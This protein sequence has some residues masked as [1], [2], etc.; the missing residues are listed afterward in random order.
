MIERPWVG[1]P[2][3][4]FLASRMFLT[5]RG[6]KKIFVW[7]PPLVDDFW[8]IFAEIPQFPEISKDLF[9][10]YLIKIYLS[11]Y[12]RNEGSAALENF[13]EKST[14]PEVYL[15]FFGLSVAFLFVKWQL[16]EAVVLM[17]EREVRL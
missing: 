5:S 3:Q 1:G 6:Q 16:R 12:R 8:P 10:N 17:C 15:S 14:Q 4:K 7:G 11:H 2:R 9:F 13:F